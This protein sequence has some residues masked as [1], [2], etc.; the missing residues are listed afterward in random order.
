MKYITIVISVFISLFFSCS[1]EQP[2]YS[3]DNITLHSKFQPYFPIGMGIHKSDIILDSLKLISSHFSSISTANAFKFEAIHPHFDEYDFKEADSI[4]SFAKKYNLKLR[5][6][7]LVWGNRNP[8]WLFWDAKGNLIHR[9]LLDQRLKDHIMTVVGR[10][11]KGIYAW[12]VVN[13][14]VY[15]NDKEWLKTNTWFKIMGPDYIYNAFRYAHEADSSA[16]LF[17]NDY[18]AEFPD[19]RKRIVQL[20]TMMKERN[21]PIHGIGIQGNW[22][23]DNLNLD[24]LEDAIDAYSA[25]G[26]T[27]QITELNIVDA[28]NPGSE[29]PAS[30]KKIAN[31]Y[32]KLF[33]VLLKHKKQ[34]S[35]VTFWQSELPHHKYFPLFDSLLNPT[36]VYQS[37][38]DAN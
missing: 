28:K 7:T 25:L 9:A 2:R 13:E 35:G 29:N 10:Y 36:I 6:H 38:L 34:I 23:T 16:L 11:K 21:V 31:A 33:K 18:N 17:Y 14:A 15:D 12:D 37:I 30:L 5:G 3:I 19:K 8:Y 26:L 4:V 27:V 20:I 1:S 24:D 22:T 32:H